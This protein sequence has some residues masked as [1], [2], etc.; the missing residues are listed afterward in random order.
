VKRNCGLNSNKACRIKVKGKEFANC[1]GYI[2]LK[3]FVPNFQKSIGIE[4]I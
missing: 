1:A 4:L 2:K 3:E